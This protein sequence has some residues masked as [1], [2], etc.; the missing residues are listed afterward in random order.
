MRKTYSKL[1]LLFFLTISGNIAFSQSSARIDVMTFNIRFG[2]LSTLEQL[3]SYIKKENPDIVA[4]QECDWKTFRFKVPQQARKAFINELA[5]H[6]GYFGLFGKSIKYGGGYYGVGILSK[7]PIIKS[8]RILLPHFPPREQRVMLLAEIEMPN[9]SVVTFI[10]THLD[11]TTDTIRQR[12]IAFINE[13]IKQIETPVIIA[14]DFNSS[15]DSKEIEE[16]FSNW[17]NATNNDYTYSTQ[18][19]KAK[20]DYIFCYPANRFVLKST[21]VHTDCLLSDHFPVTSKIKLKK[22]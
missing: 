1:I 2:E 19:P 4:L 12:Q 22:N 9:K 20:I 18:E 8:E 16:G 6:S 13:R 15:P 10:S 11:S 3:A 14:G 21:Q 17:F 7:Y 5:Y